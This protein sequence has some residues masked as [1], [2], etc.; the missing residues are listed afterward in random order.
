MARQRLNDLIGVKLTP[1]IR[2]EVEQIARRREVGMSE[3]VRSYL[4][5]GL[6]RDGV[7]C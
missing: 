4:L 7:E 2:T 6:R 3:V 5:D 1:Q